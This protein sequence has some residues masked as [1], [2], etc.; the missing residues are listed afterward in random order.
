M[1]DI[2]PRSTLSPLLTWSGSEQG[3]TAYIDLGAQ[4]PDASLYIL[5]VVADVE[6]LIGGGFGRRK[7]GGLMR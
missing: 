2:N 7:C 4:A 6:A 1:G 3:A 5:S